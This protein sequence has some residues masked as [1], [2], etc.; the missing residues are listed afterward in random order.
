MIRSGSI[1]EKCLDTII[2]QTT[3]YGTYMFINGEVMLAHAK[4]QDGVNRL[5]VSM[6]IFCNKVAMLRLTGHFLLRADL[7]AFGLLIGGGR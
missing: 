3:Y 5:D 1:V 6:T 4:P 2:A 7:R